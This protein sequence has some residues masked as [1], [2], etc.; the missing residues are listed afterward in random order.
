[1]LAQGGPQKL[2]FQ[3]VSY[4]GEDNDYPVRELLF[5]SPHTRGWQTPRFCKYP[6]EI[7][8]RLEQPCKIQQ[9]QILS[10]EYK[11][12]TKI[13]VFVASPSPLEDHSQVAFKRLGYL[14][15]DSNERSNHQARELKSVHVNVPAFYIRL[16]VQ[17]CH[18][19]KLN[20]YN[21]V[22][23]IALNLIGEPIRSR[24]VETPPGG[25]LQLH[26]PVQKHQP[27]YNQAAANVAD[28]NLDIHV[29][30]VTANKI[31]ELARA[32]DAA[33]ANEDY[34]EA[35]R[36]KASIDRLKVVGQKVA[37][38]EARKRAAVEKE[39]YDTAKLIKI[40]IDKLR[41]AGDTAAIA[42]NNEALLP[43]R[44]SPSL[45]S[46]T[47]GDDVVARVL[48]PPPGV[49]RPPSTGMTAAPSNQEPLDERP[50][51]GMTP[52]G[53]GYGGGVG[54]APAEPSANG[55]SS[56]TGGVLGGAD[57]EQEQGTAESTGAGES[58]AESAFRQMPSMNARGTAYDERP[59]KGKGAYIPPP[60]AMEEPL[61]GGGGGEGAGDPGAPPGWPRDLPAPEPLAGNTAKEA[62]A[63]EELA[64][65]YCARAFYS[66]NW[67]LR[68]AALTYLSNQVASG[69]LQSHSNA[70]RTLSGIVKRGMKD[71]L[72]NVF[73]SSLSTF[74][75]I[76]D[77]FAATVG[78][79]D[80]Q[81]LCEQC[82][83]LLLE[84]LGDTN[85]RIR[86]SAKESIMF[87]AGLKDG[88]IRNYT[89]IIMKPI[90]NQ[91]A[92]R[93]ILGV[94]TLLQDLVPLLGISK[95]GEGFDLAEL[96]E[97][98]SKPYNSANGE[99]RAMAITVTKEIFD[100]VGPGP[101]RK[102]LPSDLSPKMKEQLDAVLGG[103]PPAAPPPAAAPPAPARA[104]R[105]APAAA[106]VPNKAPAR[107][108]K[109]APAK[110]AAAPPPPPPPP[111]VPLAP[112]DPAPFEAELKQ[113][114]KALGPRHP[115]VAESCSNLAILYNQKGD[116]ARALP[117][118]QRALAIYE[119]HF[120]PDHP[121]VA[122]TLT[123][124]AVLHLEQG[125]DAVGRPL[126]ERA[127]V[128]Q[129]KALGPDHPD[130]IAIKDVLNSD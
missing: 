43:R 56:A 52:G 129:E 105:A 107:G 47:A 2:R 18:V 25:Y 128:I 125:D 88:G 103:E 70:F 61:G 71:K 79:R 44:P 84:K 49:P 118:Y 90:K 119:K 23:L 74:Q 73:L 110:A 102:F 10:H 94:L 26:P 1:M 124:L 29:D 5:H 14:S 86:E 46:P 78:G 60:D 17:R 41:A 99:V 63:L 126:L 116:T 122:H 48:Q 59:A 12:A 20:I 81:G 82:L 3:I 98:L 54:T 114:E 111:P 117:L 9:I 22:G 68:D 6:Q 101:I 57:G 21:Q 95:N 121:E 37:Q 76:V 4:S 72:A 83:P 69:E 45:Q 15:F 24:P 16:V 93:P 130:V 91:N 113:R 34:D 64:G 28:I 19:N 53:P 92:W 42:S 30:T 67:Q 13:E 127:L 104:A 51:R 120:G 40:D 7:L 65:E 115:D 123:D 97:F 50:V 106:A 36:L 77:N 85:P 89:H 109:A 58:A 39:D 66:K 27:Y 62:E 100:L 108:G 112:D 55:G 8:L 75:T 38:L 87:I 32:K 33:V 80:I 96:M 35:K 11:I 31:R